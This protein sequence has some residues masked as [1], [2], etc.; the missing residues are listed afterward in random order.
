MMLNKGSSNFSTHEEKINHLIVQEKVDI[1]TIT[2]S[3]LKDNDHEA[4][5][6]YDDRYNFENQVMTGNEESR[7]T[8]MIRKGIKYERMRRYELD[9]V[10]MC[11]VKIKCK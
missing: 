5:K 2:E 11:W 10:S 1:L 6:K 8:I 3:N 7:V 4:T 9:D